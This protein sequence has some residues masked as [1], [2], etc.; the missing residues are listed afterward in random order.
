MHIIHNIIAYYQLAGVGNFSIKSRIQ[1]QRVI[2][3]FNTLWAT[4]LMW[5]RY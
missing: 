1:L 2:G 3:D 5:F 4:S